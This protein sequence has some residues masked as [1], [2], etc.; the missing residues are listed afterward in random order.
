MSRVI[1]LT[2]VISTNC[3]AWSLFCTGSMFLFCSILLSL[4]IWPVWWNEDKWVNSCYNLHYNM[5]PLHIWYCI[6]TGISRFIFLY[7]VFK[8]YVGRKWRFSLWRTEVSFY[9]CLL[10]C[11]WIK[12]QF[13]EIHN[14]NLLLSGGRWVDKICTTRPGEGIVLLAVSKSRKATYVSATWGAAVLKKEHGG[15]KA[16]IIRIFNMSSFPIVFVSLGYQ[17]LSINPCTAYLPPNT[18]YFLTIETI[19]TSELQKNYWTSL[20]SD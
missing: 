5:L 18:R 20:I 6:I 9:N 8:S 2:L 17:K 13:P 12:G 4:F 14:A 19:W 7:S 3:F 1:F 10:N 15:M 11:G 16:S